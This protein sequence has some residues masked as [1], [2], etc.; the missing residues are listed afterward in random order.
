VC[1][2]AGRPVDQGKRLEAGHRADDHAVMCAA[3]LPPVPFDATAERPDWLDLPAGVRAA[4]ERRIGT[5]TRARTARGG[6]TRGFTAVLET[7][8]GERSF[9]KAAS[10]AEQPHLTD[11]YAREAQVIDLLPPRLPVARVRWTMAAAGYV[12]LCLDAIDGTMPR[13]P[14][15]AAELEATLTAYAAVA[16]ALREPPSDLVALGLPR[17]ADLA[18]ED[19]SCWQPIAAGRQP[20][21]P[22]PAGTADRLPELAALESRLPGYA[23]TEALIHCDLR[24]DNV[25]IDRSGRAWLCDWNWLCHGPAWFDLASLLLTAYASGHDAD[26]IFTGHP[27]ASGAPPDA[28]DSALA[29]LAGY[30]IT[31]AADEPGTATPHVRGH[32]RWSGEVALAWLA[33]RRGWR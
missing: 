11:W 3:S 33:D 21:P 4:I 1:I 19:L 28:L 20:L 30:F 8:A 6:F 22:V 18:R 29:A 23:E 14:W 15:I 26:A 24:L 31:R 13:M 25:L 17:L 32:Q 2:G 10:F 12:V 7:A 16:T 5:V 9:V 27:A